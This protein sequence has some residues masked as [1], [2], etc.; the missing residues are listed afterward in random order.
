M[1]TSSDIGLLYTRELTSSER[2]I[3]VL[4]FETGRDLTDNIRLSMLE[5]PLDGEV[6]AYNALSY[7]WGNPTPDSA[8][9]KPWL[10]SPPNPLIYNQRSIYVNKQRLDVTANL[11]FAL[12]KLRP[13]FENHPLVPCLWVD[14][15]CINQ[16]DL[17]ERAE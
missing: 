3:R 14:A 15:I 16:G 13:R 17:V 1:S 5:I 7:T 11:F 4:S 2:Q 10:T 9:K 8:R 6:V 12:K